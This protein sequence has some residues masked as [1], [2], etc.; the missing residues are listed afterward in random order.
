MSGPNDQIIDKQGTVLGFLARFWWMFA[1]NM[2][3]A[4]SLVFL[5]LNQGGFFH[6]ADW[7]YWIAVASLVSVRYLDVRFWDGQTAT[8]RRASMRDWSRYATLLLAG[9]VVVWGIAH[10]AN[11]LFVS[12]MTQG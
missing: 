5:L 1:G 3:F 2:V 8:G 10:A 6:P 7:V 11:Y 12:R 9:A 4:F